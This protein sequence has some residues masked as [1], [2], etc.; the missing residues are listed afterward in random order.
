LVKKGLNQQ[1]MARDIDFRAPD[2]RES[3]WTTG[4]KTG[5]SRVNCE[6]PEQLNLDFSFRGLYPSPAQAPPHLKF[7]ELESWPPSACQVQILANFEFDFK[8]Y[9]CFF[10]AG[11][12]ERCLF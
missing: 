7:W 6:V 1:K 9:T 8:K 2:G 12:N 4:E 5:F 3:L 10:W 11:T